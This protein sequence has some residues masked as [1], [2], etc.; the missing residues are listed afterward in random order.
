MDPVA[1]TAQVQFRVVPNHLTRVGEIV[2]S[3]TDD[4]SPT[5][6]QNS[7]T[8]KPGDPFR[9]SSVLES[10]RNLYESN[11]FRLATLQ[12][13]E[14]FD[15]V[16]TVH[17]LLREARLHEARISAGFNTVDYI[18]TEG[19]FTHYNLLGGARRLDATLTLG[20]LLANQLEGAGI[21][22]AQPVDTTITGSTVDFLSPTWNANLRFTQPAFLRRP[23]NSLSFGAFAQRRSVPA[24]EIDHGYG[25]DVTFT[26]T[27]GLR[28][29]A[30]ANY[31]FEV[32]QVLAG[33]PYFCVNFG[34]CDQTTIN[35]LRSYRRLSPVQASALIDRT[36][37]PLNP[38]SGY[39]AHA[40]L[41]YASQAT[42]SDYSYNR[43]FGEGTIYARM[44]RRNTVLAAR[45]RLGFVRPF[46]GETGQAVLHPRTRF[47]A[48]GSQSVRGYGENQLGPRILTLPH[49]FLINAQTTSGAPCD[50]SSELIRLCDPNT[51]RDSTG[52][53][54]ALIGD[55]KFTP[56][57]LGGTS[58][59]E[60]SVEYRFPLFMKNLGGA[61]FLDGAAVG[62][63]VFD[64]LRG[65]VTFKNLVSG[66][67][68]ITPGFGIRYYSPVGPIRVDLG[69][70]P[71]RPE[72][73]AVVTELERNGR[74]LLIPLDTPRSYA[75][76]GGG[77][78]IGRLLNR[79]VLHLSIGQAY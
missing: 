75:A 31:K 21:F 49:G 19:R 70:N 68:A 36:D 9:R 34:V 54:P 26:R 18:Q 23:R 42:V 79:L 39:T 72:N 51:A 17:V 33:D 38:T 4:I 45:L 16:K 46:S 73:L 8:F 35:D 55:D 53:R 29:S 25:G 71:S 28:A 13:P 1:R 58:L 6:V 37:V 10:Q 62:E 57:P 20:N 27:I 14:S 65:L 11:L 40:E 66:T 30:S 78:G 74:L 60:A 59:V 15:S 12:V 32:T 5:T 2:I 77:S 47:Y 69:I 44:G 41:A 50:A 76:G 56:S 63:R 52:L 43:M 3:G 7:L 24:V 48:G 64:P 61:V 22:H 67:G